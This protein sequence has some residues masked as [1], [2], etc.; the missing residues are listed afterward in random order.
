MKIAQILGIALY[1]GGTAF[2]VSQQAPSVFVTQAAERD[3][4]AQF[5]YVGRVEAVE[6]VDLRARVEGFVEK[7]EFREG[8]EI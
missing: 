2:G 3:V 7:R 1:F 6:T 5:E 8:S 4:T